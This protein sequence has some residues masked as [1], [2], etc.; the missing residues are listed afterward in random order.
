MRLIRYKYICFKQCTV[1]F[2]AFKTLK[3]FEGYVCCK[4]KLWR[5]EHLHR[6]KTPK[7]EE[8]CQEKQQEILI[9]HYL[10]KP[11][12]WG[13]L[14]QPFSPR[15]GGL[16]ELHEVL[17]NMDRHGDYHTKWSQSERQIPYDITC[18]WNLKCDANELAYETD[19][20]HPWAAFLIPVV[21]HIVYIPHP[22]YPFLCW[23]FRLFLYLGYCE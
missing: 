3:K 14:S 10:K 2:Q 1:K 4:N 6:K 15:T 5:N 23:T 11:K 9:L 16:F 22:L 19:S 13:W 8:E 17:S 18:V 20:L 12:W 21:F 7:F